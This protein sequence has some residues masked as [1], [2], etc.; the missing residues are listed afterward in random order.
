MNFAFD[1]GF[2]L[3]ACVPHLLLLGLEV[4]LRPLQ[5]RQPVLVVA[6]GVLQ[7]LPGTLPVLLQLGLQGGHRLPGVPHHHLHLTEARGKGAETEVNPDVSYV[8]EHK[9]KISNLF[10]DLLQCSVQQ[11]LLLLQVVLA[12]PEQFPF[13]VALLQPLAQLVPLLAQAG[14][15][16]LGLVQLGLERAVLVLQGLHLIV[17]LGASGQQPLENT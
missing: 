17:V 8:S 3:L 2:A 11:P 7:I 1:L 4:V 10:V 14:D 13:Q 15:P 16:S 6:L 12:P 9:A 5:L